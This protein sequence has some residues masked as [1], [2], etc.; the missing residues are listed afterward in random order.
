MKSTFNKSLL[1]FSE[2]P[3]MDVLKEHSA[4][5]LIE[6]QLKANQLITSTEFST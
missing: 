6:T 4:A 3:D 2:V 1:A 5:T